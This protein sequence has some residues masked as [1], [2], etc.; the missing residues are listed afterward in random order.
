VPQPSEH[1]L[2]DA[3]EVRRRGQLDPFAFDA[4]IGAEA[5]DAGDLLLGVGYS[6]RWHAD[7]HLLN[8]NGAAWGISVEGD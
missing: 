3:S 6:F 1:Y 2:P 8:R 4:G 5:M 7:Q